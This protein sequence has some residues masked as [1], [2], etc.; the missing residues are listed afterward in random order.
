M[1]FTNLE[2]LH[3][4]IS[5]NSPWHEPLF[6]REILIS[7]TEE[8]TAQIFWILNPHGETVIYKKKQAAWKE[9]TQTKKNGRFYAISSLGPW[10]AQR[11]EPVIQDFCPSTAPMG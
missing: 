2:K 4:V 5:Q 3:D 8:R 1:N 11:K 7:T 6:A 9:T 10:F